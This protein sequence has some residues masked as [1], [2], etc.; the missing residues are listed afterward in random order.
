[1]RTKVQREARVN[2]W[3]YLRECVRIYE[4]GG[5]P[6]PF[7]LDRGSCAMTWC[8]INGLDYTG[9]Q[10]RQTGKCQP[11]DAKILTANG[12]ITMGEVTL[13]TSVIVPDGIN[14][15][16]SEPLRIALASR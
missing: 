15:A 4:Q 2:V 13:N 5:E 8:F 9:M 7:R 1:M 11:L 3:Y 6:I 12:Y 14:S 16:P 10:P